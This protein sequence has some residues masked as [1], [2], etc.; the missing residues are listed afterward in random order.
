MFNER[1]RR[2]IEEVMNKKMFSPEHEVAADLTQSGNSVAR[3]DLGHTP[4]RNN[5]KK[6]EKKKKF[7]L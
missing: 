2:R 1:K 6:T 7:E 4:P 3:A 5:S